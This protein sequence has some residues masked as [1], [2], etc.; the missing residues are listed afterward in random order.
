MPAILHSRSLLV[1]SA[2]VLALVAS[3]IAEAQESAPTA[4][5][6]P[7]SPQDRYLV[8]IPAGEAGVETSAHSGRLI[9]FFVPDTERYT[10]VEPANGPFFERLQPIASIA[11]EG[12]KAGATI[13]F[14]PS[15]ATVF[16]GPL[17]H[18][19]G[20]WR[21][22]AVLDSDFTTRGHRGPG[23]LFSQPQSIDLSSTRADEVTIELTQTVPTASVPEND[24]VVFIS[25]KSAL[26]SQR[27]GREFNLRAGVVLPYGYDDLAFDR[28]MWPTIY[29]VPGFGANHLSALDAAAALQSPQGRAA[30]PQAVW[31]FLDADTPWGHSGFCDSAA[32]GPIGRALVEEFIPFLEERFRLIKSVPARVVTGHSSG[33]WSALHLQLTYPEV[34]GACFASAPDPVDFSAFQCTDLLKDLSLFVARDGSETPSYRGVLGP[35]DDRIFMTVRDEVACEYALDP[36]GK[37]GEQWAAW[38]AMWSPWDAARNAP[39]RLC[40]PVTGAIDPVTVEA[41]LAHD[42]ARV[43]EGNPAKYGPIFDERVRLLCGARDSFYLNLAVTRLKAKLDAWRAR[44]HTDEARSAD[45]PTASP[46]ASPSSASTNG[47]IE[48]IDGL[49]HDSLFPIAQIRF[50]QGMLEHLRAHGL[51]DAAPKAHESP[52]IRRDSASDDNAPHRDTTPLG[53]PR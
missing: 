19:D 53:Q 37:S 4:P 45:A 24:R 17:E 15:R 5:T 27:F 22:Q 21:V 10:A 8:R 20:K 43:F 48:V 9:L 28:R 49:T 16:G 3:R 41:W 34:F 12:V 52:R 32:N 44:S 18:F 29:V 40:D 35:S 51:N 26:L 11:V 38:D 2:L 46:A 25:R 47:S 23:N 7:P 31:V 13:T 14:E 6:A 50:H 30:L 1:L 36:D 42:L 39:R 33:G